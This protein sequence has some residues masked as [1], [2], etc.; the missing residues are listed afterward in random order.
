MT[1]VVIV[2]VGI[3]SYLLR[4]LPLFVGG[5]LLASPRAERIIANAGAA[6]LAALIVTGLDRS[7]GTA[8]ETVPTWLCAAAALVVAVRGGSMQRVLAAGALTYTAVW[9]AMSL[10]G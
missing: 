4:V 8:T 7:A 10:L 1:W 6:A 2:A 3:G 5:R 9:A